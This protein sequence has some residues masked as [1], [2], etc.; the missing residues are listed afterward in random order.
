MS[1]RKNI[2][3]ILIKKIVLMKVSLFCN[4]FSKIPEKDVDILEWLKDPTYK[5]L[6]LSL[7][8]MSRKEYIR[9]K[10]YL[11]AVTPMG[12]FRER[13]N[14]G[15]ISYSGL[16][17]IDIDAN[18]NKHITDWERLKSLI[19]IMIPSY[20]IGLSTSGDGLML[21]VKCNRLDIYKQCLNIVYSTLESEL[22][23]HP[24]RCCADLCRLRFVSYDPS[25]Y[26]N[27]G[28]LPIEESWL[29]VR[30]PS[31]QIEWT[32]K[33]TSLGYG[34]QFKD[35]KLLEFILKNIE[36]YQ[37][38]ITREYVAWFRIGCAIATITDV[39]SYFHRIS[40][41][42]PEYDIYACEKQFQACKKYRNHYN[43][44]TIFYYCKYYGLNFKEYY[45]K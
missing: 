38:D 11:P 4:C 18:D 17:C 39:S 44:G 36:L 45:G 25:P 7:R 29:M 42:H 9:T 40:K 15:L 24:D 13:N 28:A 12:I 27:A 31:E 10:K 14:N 5:D 35:I 33:Q 6:I 43:I 1:N 2:A 32:R 3:E 30:Y 34:Y 26:I 41:F 20:Y 19:P 21:L 8:N 23:I 37:I 22:K 16:L